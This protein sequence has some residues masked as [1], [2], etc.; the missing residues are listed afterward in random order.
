MKKIET[1]WNNIFISRHDH[2]FLKNRSQFT[3]VNTHNSPT[4][5]NKPIGCYQ[6]SVFSSLLFLIFTLDIVY[7]SHKNI[8]NSHYSYNKCTNPN[9]HAYVDDAY[10]IIVDS[11]Y[12]LWN[13]VKSYIT[14]INKYY[15]DNKL[16]NNSSKSKIMFISNNNKLKKLN[17]NINDFTFTHNSSIK[18]LGTTINDNLD[19]STHLEKGTNSLFKSLKLRKNIIYHLSNNVSKQ[20]AMQYSNAIFM[21][22]LYYHIEVWG[23]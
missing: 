11:E 9:I 2:E 6:G 18:I 20:F 14:L 21:S 17:I 22:K 19:W 10:G 7:L 8:H 13:S 15:S 16:I 5:L 1:Y 12:K 23:Q 4:I 3:Q